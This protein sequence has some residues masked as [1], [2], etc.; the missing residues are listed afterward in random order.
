M[1]LNYNL[2]MTFYYNKLIIMTL[3]KYPLSIMINYFIFLYSG[4]TIQ[5]L[6]IDTILIVYN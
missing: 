4:A 5:K 3:F 1:S 2:V 6:T